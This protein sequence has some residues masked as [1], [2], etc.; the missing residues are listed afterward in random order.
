[1]P[2]LNLVVDTDAGHAEAVDRLA[3]RTAFERIIAV[4]VPDLAGV[5]V[6]ADP[7]GVIWAEPVPLPGELAVSVL[8]HARGNTLTLERVLLEIA[9]SPSAISSAE[10][11]A[12]QR[13]IES[14]G[15]L[16]KVRVIGSQMREREQE[17]LVRPAGGRS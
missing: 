3:V 4:D 11:A 15:I 13:R 8:A 9:R 10:L 1:M 5:D 6:L 2:W 16:F 14:R 17:P 12:L 7:E